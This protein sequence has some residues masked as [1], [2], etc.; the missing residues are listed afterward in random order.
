MKTKLFVLFLTCITL[1]SAGTLE[2]EMAI[3]ERFQEKAKHIDEIMMSDNQ[4]PSDNII[5]SDDVIPNNAETTA[6]GIC[7]AF[8]LKN[9]EDILENTHQTIKKIIVEGIDEKL[10]DYKT[11]SCNVTKVQEDLETG[12]TYI[13]FGKEKMLIVEDNEKYYWTLEDNYKDELYKKMPPYPETA[14][15]V[16]IA[17]CQ[18]LKEKKWPEFLGYIDYDYLAE[19]KKMVLKIKDTDEFSKLNCKVNDI[20]NKNNG[21]KSFNFSKLGNIDLK[22]IDGYWYVVKF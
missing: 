9:K 13:Y 1:L 21:I 19:V 8:N 16:A 6:I 5:L 14:I 2:E 12:G 10:K 15:K 20:K 18:T 3:V 11:V 7:E 22:K 4:F 17:T